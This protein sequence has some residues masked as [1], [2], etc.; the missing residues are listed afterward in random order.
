[1]WDNGQCVLNPN[2]GNDVYSECRDLLRNNVLVD[3]LDSGRN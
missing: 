1:M 2:R 3:T